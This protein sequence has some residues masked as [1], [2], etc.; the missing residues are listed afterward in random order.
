MSA[1]RHV[2]AS[3]VLE[4]ALRR[5]RVVLDRAVNGLVARGCRRD[6]C[7]LDGWP[8]ALRAVWA[9]GSDAEDRLRHRFD[10]AFP[11]TGLERVK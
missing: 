6:G 9:T 4:R 2:C 3:T 1:V 11:S 8:A 10:I 5:S 7:D